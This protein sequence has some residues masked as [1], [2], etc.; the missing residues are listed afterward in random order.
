MIRIEA[1]PRTIRRT[2][3]RHIEH[4]SMLLIHYPNQN[5]RDIV[6]ERHS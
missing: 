1:L 3:L 2:N 4:G 6:Y 5:Y